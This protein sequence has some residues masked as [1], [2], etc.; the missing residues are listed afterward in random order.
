MGKI[1]YSNKAIVFLCTIAYFVGYISRKSFAVVMA[2]MISTPGVI[3]KDVAGL[4]GTA[5][6]IFYGAGQLIIKPL[7][8][9]NQIAL[10]QIVYF[11]I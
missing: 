7:S 10:M 3:S 6:F 4:V 9:S 2:D 1:K 5:L 8:K 11:S